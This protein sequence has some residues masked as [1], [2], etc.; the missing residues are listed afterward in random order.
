M[1]TVII[2]TEN[3]V[4]LASFYEKALGI[5]PFER[6]P[7]HLGC[8]VGPVYFGFDQVESAKTGTG[9][10][11]LWFTVNDIQ[12]IFAKLVHLEVKVIY[13]PTRKP[14]GAL[15]AAVYDPDGNVLGLSQ[16]EGDEE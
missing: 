7:G 13:P 6:M 3:M 10:A 2:F 4:D 14:W 11:T 8:Q 5:G 16:R 1:D 12:T 15:L 9:G